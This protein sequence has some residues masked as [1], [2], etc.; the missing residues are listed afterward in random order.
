MQQ[1][2]LSIILNGHEPM[3]EQLHYSH[4]GGFDLPHLELSMLTITNQFYNHCEKMDSK[5][6]LWQDKIHQIK[7]SYKGLKC[8]CCC[9]NIQ[10][11]EKQVTYS[12]EVNP[13]GCLDSVTA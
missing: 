5:T 10:G 2:T 7:M 13:S 4:W 8:R 6:K 9:N 1:L 11:L 12:A 3:M